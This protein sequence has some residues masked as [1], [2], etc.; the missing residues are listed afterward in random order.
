MHYFKTNLPADGYGIIGL[1]LMDLYPGEDWNFVLG[2]SS[3][4]DGCAEVSSGH[5][6]PQ[7]YQNRHLNDTKSQKIVG[8]QC[9]KA[10]G[11]ISSVSFEKNDHYNVSLYLE[12]FAD[13][14]KGNKEIIWR[15]L[16]VRCSK[17]NILCQNVHL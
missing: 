7:S 4:E 8:V 3:C 2:E 16:R 1:T 5:S 14:E 15:L 11:T 13:I 12:D 10:D 6:E 9:G 17:T